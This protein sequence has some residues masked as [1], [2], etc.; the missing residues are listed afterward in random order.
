MEVS[1]NAAASFVTPEDE[2]AVASAVPHSDDTDDDFP[3]ASGP[4]PL[5]RAPSTV[6][7]PSR[8]ESR[9]FGARETGEGEE[10]TDAVDDRSVEGVAVF[11]DTAAHS[12]R[13]DPKYYDALLMVP[14]GSSRKSS[15]KR[16]T[17]LNEGQE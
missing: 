4:R 12:S 1:N 16:V 3:T 5:V 6:E 15:P 17:T 2:V 7:D 8:T 9:P 13:S 11:R 10:C 14:A